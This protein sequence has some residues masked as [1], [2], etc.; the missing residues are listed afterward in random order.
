MFYKLLNITNFKI[1][2]AERVVHLNG[3][4]KS[5]VAKNNNLSGV[6]KLLYSFQ[7]HSK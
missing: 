2:L 6:R 7:E 4:Q 1:R 3:N 5:V